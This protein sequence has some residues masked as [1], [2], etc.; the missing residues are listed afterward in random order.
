MLGLKAPKTK[1]QAFTPGLS[2]PDGGGLKGHENGCREWFS[3]PFRT[4]FCCDAYPRLKPWALILR[5]F[6]PLQQLSTNV[7]KHTLA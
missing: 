2:T 3:R 7:I 1:A 6:R 5:P 4:V